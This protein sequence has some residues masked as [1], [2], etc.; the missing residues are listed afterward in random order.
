M[1]SVH[2]RFAKLTTVALASSVA[3]GGLAHAQSPKTNSQDLIAPH[4]IVLYIH[5]DL[6][7]T[8]F[9]EPLVCA[10]KRVLIANAETKKIRLP[11]GSAL[12]ASPTQFDV[13]QV[14]D[15]F[16]RAAGGGPLTYK[17]LLIP[18]DL[19]DEIHRYVFAT[20]FLRHR[21]G[22]VS[23]ARLEVTDPILSR[24]GRAEMTALR[25]YKLILKSIAR[26]A[27]YGR[28]NGC[29][30]TFPRNVD[31]LDL[32]SSE[33]CEDDRAALVDAGILKTEETVGCAFV[34]EAR[35][36]YMTGLARK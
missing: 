5:S 15:Q 23:T 12:L 30:L 16:V 9:V 29:I 19:K 36:G 17:Y 1:D 21:D 6:K 31:D 34:A 25:I 14:S 4:D 10:L 2:Q 20:S 32:K 3:A 27:G 35:R 11:L 24:Q 22:I 7:N 13:S 18:Y 8:N 28:S 33:F 26:L